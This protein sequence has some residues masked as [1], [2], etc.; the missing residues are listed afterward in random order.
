M[1][2]VFG[3]E[4]RLDRL[5][6][7]ANE[8]IPVLEAMVQER[9]GSAQCKAVQPEGYLILAKCRAQEHHCAQRACLPLRDESWETRRISVGPSATGPRDHT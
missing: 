9:E 8:G 7:R 5:N 6:R 1:P 3:C 2:L 4:R